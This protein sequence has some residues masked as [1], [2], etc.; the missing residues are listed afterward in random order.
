MNHARTKSAA[1]VVHAAMLA[2]MVTVVLPLGVLLVNRE[3]P[4][5]AATNLPM[6][7]IP[8]PPLSA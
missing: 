3:P 2:A 5:M 1:H 6:P 7:P 4:P 8:N